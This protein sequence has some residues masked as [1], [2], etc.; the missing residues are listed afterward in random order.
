MD[1]KKLVIGFL[2]ALFLLLAFVFWIGM[3]GGSQH[4]PGE[5]N[6]VP[7]DRSDAKDGGSVN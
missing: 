5:A 6:P 3:T 4:V 2:A 1:G 7:H